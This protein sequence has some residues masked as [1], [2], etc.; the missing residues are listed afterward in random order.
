MHSGERPR[1]EGAATTEAPSE[2]QKADLR[3]LIAGTVLSALQLVYLVSPVDLIPD[4]FPIIGWLDDGLGLLTAAT[5]TG[6]GVWK[7]RRHPALPEVSPALA[8]SPARGPEP[9]AYEPLS[10]EEIR[11]L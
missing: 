8:A 5:V 1:H 4:I 2:E 10:A 7:L 11:G 6:Y 3:W 9:A